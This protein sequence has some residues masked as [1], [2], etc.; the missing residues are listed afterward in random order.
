MKPLHRCFG[1]LIALASLFLAGTLSAQNYPSRPIRVIGPIPPGVPLDSIVRL[2]NA[3][4]GERLGT[5]VVMENRVGGD[6]IIAV[7]TAVKAPADGYTLLASVSSQSVLPSTKKDLPYDSV[8]DFI[9]MT[10]YINFQNILLANPSF[11]PNTFQEL[12]AYTKANPGKVDYGT[13]SR[14]GWLHLVGELVAREAGISW[15]N[16]P[17]SGNQQGVAN[18]I[19]GHIPVLIT[20]VAEATPYIKAGKI[21]PLVIVGTKRSPVLPDVPALSEI[22][23]LPL[24]DVDAWAGFMFRSGTPRPIVERVHGELVAVLRLQEVREFILKL[25]GGLVDESME[26]FSKKYL[27]DIDRWKRVFRESNIQLN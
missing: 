17:F 12:V 18:L 21:K 2:I 14:G 16:I 7:D 4:L 8:K 26:S 15:N 19:G 23:G 1:T 6:G 22:A 25:G 9:P 3:K 13:S 24:L 20:V 11:P 27:D 10:R 5:P